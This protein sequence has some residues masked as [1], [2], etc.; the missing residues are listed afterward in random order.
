MGPGGEG[1]PPVPPGFSSHDPGPA[2]AVYSPDYL[3]AFARFAN[4]R[5]IVV[6]KFERNV[7]YHHSMSSK[8]GFRVPWWK[9]NDTFCVHL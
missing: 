1:P 2:P 7:K 6:G 4:K 8:L 9:R 3:A 5:L